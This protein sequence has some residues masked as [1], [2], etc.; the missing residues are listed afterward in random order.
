MRPFTS[1][2]FALGSDSGTKGFVKFDGWRG[3]GPAGAVFQAFRL[4]YG[5][6]PSDPDAALL[7]ERLRSR[8]AP[9][10]RKP[11]PA[12][13]AELT[14]SRQ[15]AF[16]GNLPPPFLAER[17]S[18]G[19]TANSAARRNV[20]FRVKHPLLCRWAAIGWRASEPAWSNSFEYSPP[21]SARLPMRKRRQTA[22]RFAAILHLQNCAR[23]INPEIVSHILLTAA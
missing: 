23:G 14:R 5:R 13:F 15:A 7:A 18:P 4:C 1:R 17:L 8:Q 9:L 21:G 19:Q 16:P 12:L 22:Y 11:L 20:Q 6:H 2:F 3:S 10:P